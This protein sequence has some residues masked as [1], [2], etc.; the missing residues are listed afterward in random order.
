MTT[1]AAGDFVLHF[2]A[3]GQIVGTISG[4]PAPGSTKMGGFAKGVEQDA[5]RD[6]VLP[7][8]R[9]TAARHADHPAL[10]GMNLTPAAWEH[11]LQAVVEVESA[12]DP[13]A[14]SSA[15]ARGLAQLMPATAASLGVDIDDPRENLDGGA[16]YLLTQLA[17]FGAI[18]LALAAYNAGPAAVRRYGG[19]PPYAETRHYV[20][21]VTSE[22]D[23]LRGMA[24][25][26][27]GGNDL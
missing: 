25:P 4:R 13:N 22:F 21:R 26:F 7:T 19:V 3:A 12:F 10:A 2:D 5:R 24:D 11:L 23:R 18:D 27:E 9:L 16:R 6:E 8:L 1:G 15:G 17:D 14:V 20:A